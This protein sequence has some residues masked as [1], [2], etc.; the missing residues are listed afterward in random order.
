MRFFS[1]VNSKFDVVGLV[2]GNNLDEAFENSKRLKIENATVQNIMVGEMV[3]IL[4]KHIQSADSVGIDL[5]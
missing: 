2:I 3:Q 1:V 5:R 4:L